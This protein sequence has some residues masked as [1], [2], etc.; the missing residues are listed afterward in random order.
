[1]KSGNCELNQKINAS[2]GCN[3][4][5]VK[6]GRRWSSG[7]DGGIIF[8]KLAGKICFHHS[9]YLC[10]AI[11]IYSNKG[12][13]KIQSTPPEPFYSKHHCVQQTRR[14]IP[15]KKTGVC[16]TAWLLH[17]TRA[18]SIFSAWLQLQNP[19]YGMSM[20]SCLVLKARV[21]SSRKQNLCPQ[22]YA[23]IST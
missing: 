6:I 2:D 11:K 20:E 5:T 15:A 17:I 19:R 8:S 22:T 12:K 18:P 13:T 16:V 9:L 21:K 1:M 7:H 14:R 3:L 4:F 23:I 10:G